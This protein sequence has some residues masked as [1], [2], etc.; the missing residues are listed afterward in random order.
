MNCTSGIA[1]IKNPQYAAVI[2]FP[3]G[4]RRQTMWY[5][6]RQAL[7]ETIEDYAFWDST[8]LLYLLTVRPRVRRPPPAHPPQGASS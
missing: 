1:R 3:Q 5:V 4:G 7:T 2:Q 8:K 6:T